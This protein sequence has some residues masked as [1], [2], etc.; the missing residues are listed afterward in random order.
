MASGIPAI[1]TSAGAMPEVVVDGE[2]GF[3]VAENDPAALRAALERL[4]RN[5]ALAE[6]MGAR[7]R[8]RVLERF[9]W[10]RVAEACLARYRV[11]LAA[12]TGR[13]IRAAR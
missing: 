13:A 2:T 10:E 3:V 5:P 7:G 4:A 12:R 11:L 6:A 1:C 8:A 9:S